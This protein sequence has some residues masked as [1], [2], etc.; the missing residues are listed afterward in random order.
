M[1]NKPEYCWKVEHGEFPDRWN[2]ELIEGDDRGD[3]AVLFDLDYSGNKVT[4]LSG[5]ENE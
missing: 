1:S 3:D 2:P 5:W 4:I